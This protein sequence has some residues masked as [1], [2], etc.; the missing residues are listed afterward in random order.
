MP[1]SGFPP[2]LV[3]SGSQTFNVLSSH[4]TIFYIYNYMVIPQNQ[5]CLSSQA[6]RQ[7]HDT[8]ISDFVSSLIVLKFL[9]LKVGLSPDRWASKQREEFWGIK[10]SVKFSLLLLLQTDTSKTHCY[11]CIRSY[12]GS[13]T[14][15][16][17]YIWQF[18]H[19]KWWWRNIGKVLVSEKAI[20]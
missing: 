17:I 16:P 1:N 7:L 12:P 3:K 15:M 11:I 5:Y 14:A 19:N 6:I 20:Q 10:I 8:Q 18:F 9:M 13:K 4:L 2:Y